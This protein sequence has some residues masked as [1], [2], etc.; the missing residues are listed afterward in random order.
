MNTTEDR[1]T[2]IIVKR[3]TSLSF[4]ITLFIVV[5]IFT[6]LAVFFSL[7]SQNLHPG[8]T[9]IWDNPDFVITADAKQAKAFDT[10]AVTCSALGFGVLFIFVIACMIRIYARP[11]RDIKNDIPCNPEEKT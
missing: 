11:K 6:G 10:Y 7:E 4:I 2:Q 3:L 1:L 8:I 5:V 9:K